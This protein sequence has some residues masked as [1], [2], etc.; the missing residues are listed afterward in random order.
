MDV[1]VRDAN[2][3]ELFRS[4]GTYQGLTNTGTDVFERLTGYGVESADVAFTADYVVVTLA[5]ADVERESSEV[6][7][8]P[9]DWPEYADADAGSKARASARQAL[10]T[11]TGAFG[12]LE[13]LAETVDTPDGSRSEADARLAE[14]PDLNDAFALLADL[15][16]EPDA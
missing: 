9:Q 15:F 2:G 14:Y 10:E 3:N 8:R 11:I 16:A 5:L 12:D 7:Y 1:I 6:F 13:S 4:N